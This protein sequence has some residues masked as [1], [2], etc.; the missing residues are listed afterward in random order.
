MSVSPET[1]FDFD[2]W[3]S[4]ATVAELSV[5]IFQNGAV[6]GKF[7]EWKRR[8]ER[9]VAL[10]AESGGE[11]S[12]GEVD[13][14]AELEAEGEELL[15]ELEAAKTVWF[16]RALTNED[17]IAIEAAH[18]LPESP[19]KK[20]TEPAPQAVRG[21]TEKQ[22]EAFIVAYTSWAERKAAFD[23]EQQATPEYRAW[24][25]EASDVLQGRGAEKIHR[26]FKRI[27][28]DGKVLTDVAPS[29]A[30]IRELPRVL[31]ELQVG[32]LIAKIEAATEFEPEVAGD[33][34]RRTSKTAHTS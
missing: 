7:D 13:P 5:D 19:A 16:L 18:P 6:L 25:R 9:A 12:A 34:L 17:E 33:F 30:Q 20:W 11:R 24:L 29:V 22:A 21:A 8:Y 15:K 26:A 27:E 28:K 3:L 14:V 32:Q 1:G 10:S 2:S 23:D 31:G 4:G